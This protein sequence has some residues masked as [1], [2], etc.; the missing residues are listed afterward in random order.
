MTESSLVYVVSLQ[1]GKNEPRPTVGVYTGFDE[2]MAY[3]RDY[4]EKTGEVDH[5]IADYEHYCDEQAYDEQTS[6]EQRD[7]IM[8]NRLEA[9]MADGQHRLGPNFPDYS[10]L[11]IEE[12]KFNRPFKLNGGDDEDDD[13]E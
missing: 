10:Y 12:L 8:T 4:F 11:T 2:T 13:E 5:I 7:R 1:L 9:I 3:I 6:D